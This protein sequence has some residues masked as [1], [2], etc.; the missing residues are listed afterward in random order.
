MFINYKGG[1]KIR[2]QAILLVITFVFALTLCGAVFAE[3][4][5]TEVIEPDLEP[6]GFLENEEISIQSSNQSKMLKDVKMVII[7]TRLQAVGPLVNAYKNELVPAGYDFE[8]KIYDSNELTLNPAYFQLLGEDLKNTDILYMFHVNNP[9]TSDLAPLI[10][11]MPAHAQIFQ[12]ACSGDMSAYGKGV[13]DFNYYRPVFGA[14]LSQE[15]LKRAVLELL[16]RTDAIELDPSETEIVPLPKEFLYHPDTADIFLNREDYLQWYA[17]AGK[18]KENAPWIGVVFH[19]W[20]YTGN[21][22][23][24]YH[25]LVRELEARGANVMA[26]VADSNR[27]A[28][29]REFFMEDG[30][31]II[32]SMIAHLHA[33]YGTGYEQLFKDMNIPIINPVHVAGL[34]D[35]Y[36]NNNN[37]Y[38]PGQVSSAWL[39]TPELHG[40]I[41]PILIGGTSVLGTDSTTG[42]IIKAFAPYMPG[43]EQLAGRAI[44]WAQLKILENSDK[45]IA[46]I[47]FDNTHDEGMPVGGSL[48]IEASLTS[49]LKA[50][51][52]E[53]YNLGEA[54][55]ANLTPEALLDLIK[56]QGRNLVNY[57]PSDLQELI[58]KGAVTITRER[59]LELYA[60]LPEKLRQEVEAQWGPPIGDVKVFNDLIV[61]PGF[62]LGNIFL[63]PQPIWKWNGVTSTLFDDTTLPP[64]HQYIAFYLW[65]EYEFKANAVIHTGEH[66]TIELLPGRSVALTEDDWPNTLIGTM[67]HIYIYN[68]ANDHAK[69]RAYAVLISHLIPPVVE[70]ELYGS[71]EEIHDLIKSY[72]DA[73]NKGETQ[74]QELLENQIR[75][76]LS[77]E[78]ELMER[79]AVTSDT[80]FA[81]ILQKLH[82]YI[83]NMQ[84]LLIPYGKH[85]F[86][87]LPDHEVLEKFV[88]AIVAYDPQN[89]EAIRNEIRNLL[90]QS[91]SS[92]M[93]AL[94]NALNAGYIE[95]GIA[96]SPIR[97]LDALP[98]GR[99]VYSF[100][101]RSVPDEPAMII[102]T[103]AAKAMLERYLAE[104]G[105]KYPTTVAIT[106]DGGEVIRTNGQ[107]IAAIFYFLGV[108]PIYNRGLVVG[109]EVIPLAELGRPRIDVLI[110]ASVS[111]RDTCPYVVNIIDDAIKQVALLDESLDNNFVRKNYLSMME[112]LNTEL[113]SQGMSPAE[114]LVQAERLARA[115]IFGLPPGAD[116][117]GMGVARILRS[118]ETWTEEELLETFLDYNTY[119]YGKGLNG[120]PGRMVMEK[121]I[122][123]VDSS[124][125][126]SDSPTAGGRY[127]GMASINFVVKQLTGRDISSYVVRTGVANTHTHDGSTHSHGVQVLSLK[128]AVFDNISLT[129]LNPVWKEGMLKEGYS[130]QS[131]IALRIRSLFSL[132]ALTGSVSPEQWQK[133]ANTYLFD[134]QLYSQLDP[135]V[136]EMI[137]NVI[138]Q[139]DNRGFME[140]TPEQAK[141][142]AEM[143]GMVPVDDGG[144]QL[145][146]IDPGVVPPSNPGSPANPGGTSSPGISQSVSATSVSQSAAEAGESAGEESQTAYEVSKT[147]N[148]SNQVDSTPFAAIVGVL[149]ISGLIGVGFFKGSILSFLGFAKK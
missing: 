39:I 115:R 2:K 120:V 8:L 33:S 27:V 54:D 16:R 44:A 25:A 80:E 98:T 78:P 86:G 7:S 23:A 69:R 37:P 53:G 36:L 29:T 141:K 58:Q 4:N 13:T 19:N 136:A 40:R 113:K 49:I 131:T 72:D 64:T 132:S 67:P 118:S 137:R 10:R 26:Y 96:R 121:L 93:N 138:H 63:G 35:E 84:M 95:P 76:K 105:G 111:F 103:E 51:Q 21:D 3:E 142:L 41:E 100:D 125:M 11:G 94:L 112:K 108:K 123:T 50:L 85:T 91:A 99:N 30:K 145:P 45:K 61:I 5:N 146:G 24:V 104:N 48:N 147:E 57:T 60:T 122:V 114:A 9:L 18:L 90:I 34:L 110:S 124:M 47:Y 32:Q 88:D 81:Q 42:A 79:L 148:P 102:G 43:I 68:G 143:M 71:L 89:R 119:L 83:H 56:Y 12:T 139:A 92:E 134:E 59:Y 133:V 62:M 20:Y 14:D 75:G 52:Q 107:S 66:G 17:A 97:A 28:K 65:L 101:P 128:E 74:R 106:V 73:K 1:E 149:L 31:P 70:T 87:E 140:L 15:N 130:G 127:S 117:H 129:L 46:L 126:I 38:N 6:A 55:I 144:E 109:T 82:T 77:E 135:M 22:M 116:P